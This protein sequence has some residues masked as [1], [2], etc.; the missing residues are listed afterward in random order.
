VIQELTNPLEEHR[1]RG[2]SAQASEAHVCQWRVNRDEAVLANI[3]GY[4][5]AFVVTL[6][7]RRRQTS[8]QLP[9]VASPF[10]LQLLYPSPRNV[11]SLNQAETHNR[12]ASVGVFP[13]R[14]GRV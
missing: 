14:G 10:G 7:R 2:P 6:Q 1:I 8:L 13:A 12:I 9:T 3:Q 11:E 4:V 5:L